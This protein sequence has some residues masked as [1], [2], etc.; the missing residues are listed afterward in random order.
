VP[1][2]FLLARTRSLNSAPAGTTTPRPTPTCVI[3]HIALTIADFNRDR[4]KVEL[5]SLGVQNVRDGGAYS[6]HMTDPFGYD[7]QVSGLE[8]NAISDGA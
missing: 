1:L 5:A 8:N 6:L 2:T 3:D 4:A 7:I